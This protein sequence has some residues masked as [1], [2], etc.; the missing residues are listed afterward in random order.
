MTKSLVCCPSLRTNRPTFFFIQFIQTR[1]HCNHTVTI[2]TAHSLVVVFP[3][4][5]IFLYSAQVMHSA[6]LD[7]LSRLGQ[8]YES[9][10][11]WG[12]G[13]AIIITHHHYHHHCTSSQWPVQCTINTCDQTGASF[14]WY[15]LLCPGYANY[16]LVTDNISRRKCI[17][18]RR[19]P[20]I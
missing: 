5:S 8:L 18:W 9:E 6:A 10:F 12:A 19:R 20:H 1:F 15:C 16:N 17:V 4:K 13:I 2:V 11:E 3:R 14:A 7:A